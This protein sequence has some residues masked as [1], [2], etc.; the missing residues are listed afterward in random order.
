[1]STWWEAWFKLAHD[2]HVNTS[3]LNRANVPSKDSWHLK[4]LGFSS[5]ASTSW[6]WT[7]HHQG[8]TGCVKIFKDIVKNTTVSNFFLLK[9]RHCTK[10]KIFPKICQRIKCNLVIAPASGLFVQ[11]LGDYY[12]NHAWKVLWKS[13]KSLVMYEVNYDNLVQHAH[14]IKR[15]TLNSNANSRRLERL[16][17]WKNFKFTNS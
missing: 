6:V 2:F 7:R 15:K 3:D 8:G 4:T 10:L 17:R 12:E 13:T 9:V 16:V 5:L 14:I 11:N 1:M